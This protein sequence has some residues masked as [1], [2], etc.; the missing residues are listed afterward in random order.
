LSSRAPIDLSKGDLKDLG[1]EVQHCEINTKSAY[2]YI[3]T[4]GSFDSPKAANEVL[5]QVKQKGC[6]NAFVRKL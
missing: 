3:Y 5:A 1:Q 6:S 2:K 4:L